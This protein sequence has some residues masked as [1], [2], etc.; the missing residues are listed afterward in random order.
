MKKTSIIAGI[1]VLA[2]ILT[3]QNCSPTLFKN[4]TQN[5]SSSI[6]EPDPDPVTPVNCS[7]LEIRELDN[8]IAGSEFRLE[9]YLIPEAA[10]TTQYHVQWQTDLFL[11]Q[12]HDPSNFR[13]SVYPDNNPFVIKA[14]LLDSSEQIVAVCE[15]TLPS[16]IFEDGFED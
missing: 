9:A 14:T 6:S 12:N 11:F 15:K 3:F 10:D 13:V 1:C 8:F 16:K 2:L 7:Q 4:Q 5:I